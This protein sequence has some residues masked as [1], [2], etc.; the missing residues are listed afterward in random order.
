MVGEII[1]HV[2][3][4]IMTLESSIRFHGACTQLKQ[5][6]TSKTEWLQRVT[7]CHY[8]N[9]NVTIDTIMKKAYKGWCEKFLMPV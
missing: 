2:L 1:L 7:N 6:V 8:T 5:E 4:L 3:S 9:A